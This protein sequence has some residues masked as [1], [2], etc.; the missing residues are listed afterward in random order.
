MFHGFLSPERAMRRRYLRPTVYDFDV[1]LASGPFDKKMIL[2][3]QNGRP[4]PARVYAAGCPQLDKYFHPN[5]AKREYLEK[6]SLRASEPVIVYAPHWFDFRPR[7]GSKLALFRDIVAEL[8]KLPAQ[9]V[10]KPHRMSFVLGQDSDQDWDT[11]MREIESEQVR[12][13]LGIEDADALTV[14]DVVITGNDSGRAYISMLL[15]KP[16][17]LFPAPPRPAGTPAEAVSDLLR[18]GAEVAESISEMGN[19]ARQALRNPGAKAKDRRHVGETI[20]ANPGRSTEEVVK[21][22]YQEIQPA[23]RVTV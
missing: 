22:L 12:V 7:G 9:I 1:V 20:L 17:I 3:H 19:L 6:L 13:D 18:Q 11:L 14:A 15:N 5:G 16:V 2:A 23:D 4:K 8:R 21:L 10:V